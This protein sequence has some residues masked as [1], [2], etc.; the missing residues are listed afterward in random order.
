MRAARFW[1]VWPPSKFYEA[2][3]ED[4]AIAIAF[5]ETEMAVTAYQS[6]L[7]QREMNKGSNN[8]A[9]DND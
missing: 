1:N 2:S 5:Y 4:Q 7:D 6:K 8:F 9:S 3:L